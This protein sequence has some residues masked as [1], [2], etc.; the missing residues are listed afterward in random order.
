MWENNF[1]LPCNHALRWSPQPCQ[2]PGDKAHA[3]AQTPEPSGRP[4]AGPSWKGDKSRAHGR[5]SGSQGWKLRWHPPRGCEQGRPGKV[6]AALSQAFGATCHHQ[7]IRNPYFGNL[8]A[9]PEFFVFSVIISLLFSLSILVKPFV[10]MPA[11]LSCA[12]WNDKGVLCACLALCF[13]GGM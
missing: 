13:N 2:P 1:P 9:G 12:K 5:P 8:A 6:P 11:G 7:R 3:S 10:K 4:R